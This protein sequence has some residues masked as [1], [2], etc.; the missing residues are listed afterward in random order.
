MLQL[1]KNQALQYLNTF[2][3]KANT[4]VYATFNST[5]DIQDVIQLIKKENYKYLVLGGGSNILF[6]QDFDGIIIKP[7][8]QGIE[9]TN[10][11]P[12]Y[13]DV[14]AGAGVSWDELVEWTVT[15][16]L[17]GLEN[18][19]YIPGNAGASPIQNIG[20]YGT[21]AKDSL[22][23]VEIFRFDTEKKYVLKNHDCKFD[24]RYSIFKDELA[25]KTLITHVTYRLGKHPGFNLEYGN[26]AKEVEKLGEINL[27]NIRDA[28]VNIR[29]QKLPDP[30]I[31]GNAGSFFK[32][33]I[34][35]KEKFSNL[36]DKY[37][38]MP[39]YVVTENESKIPAAYLIEK[40]GWKGYRNGDAG[41]HAY[42]P[43]VLVNYG[44]ANGDE[45][46]ALARKIQESVYEKF[47]IHIHM[48]VNIV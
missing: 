5:N 18:L 16:G 28:V 35:S 27:R 13:A 37:P 10:E 7:D 17:G 22:L 26:L 12:A 47:D 15:K 14:K 44:N 11:T 29:K 23:E 19:S 39:E 4:A 41:V 33:P 43:L 36:K 24:Y 1:F 21:E 46:I 3:I 9:I 20:A 31:I 34:I 48:E 8:I 45:I 42:Q 30:E 40:C 38:D 6:K 2:K 32:N 25:N